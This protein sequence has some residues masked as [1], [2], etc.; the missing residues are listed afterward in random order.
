[1]IVDMT[2]AHAPNDNRLRILVLDD[3]VFD[4]KKVA[5]ENENTI[6]GAQIYS[7]WFS[8]KVV[9]ELAEMSELT[10]RSPFD[11]YIL[12]N[13]LCE[14]GD[15][16]TNPRHKSDGTHVT[17]AG[18][19]AGSMAA[20]RW[21]GHVQALIPWSA[22][23]E[24]GEDFLTLLSSFLPRDGIHF[25]DPDRIRKSS[26]GGLLGVLD[27]H[28]AVT[29]RKALLDAVGAGNA[30]FFPGVVGEFRRLLEVGEEW[31]DSDLAIQVA[32]AAGPRTFTLGALFFEKK[33][34]VGSRSCVPARAVG[35]LLRASRQEGPIFERAREI[36]TVFWKLRM[37]WASFE[38]YGDIRG[39]RKPRYHLT[40]PWLGAREWR[41]GEGVTRERDG[42]RAI[43]L[44]ILFLL[45]LEHRTRSDA[46]ELVPTLDLRSRQVLA[47]LQRMYIDMD[48][49]KPSRSGWDIGRLLRS[50]WDIGV[51]AADALV[52]AS[53]VAHDPQGRIIEPAAFA[54]LMLPAT[55]LVI[56]Y[57]VDP[58]PEPVVDKS[59]NFQY[60]H[61]IGKDT[62]VRKQ[63]DRLLKGDRIDEPAKTLDPFALLSCDGATTQQM[64]LAD[65][66]T[67][68]RRFAAGLMPESKFPTWLRVASA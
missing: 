6:E 48:E 3:R 15:K 5:V 59:G 38:I 46:V 1:M 33:Q 9:S 34:R 50:E 36:A 13:F 63:F 51:E 62:K 60:T 42:V 64:L 45:L 12:D 30:S 44:A 52:R 56:L 26:V 16:C 17:G 20:N 4:D 14:A 35:E 49:D 29:Y 61:T 27:K 22:Y 28:A 65:E 10:E 24:Q 66:W 55:E 31:V 18:L 47:N 39:G 37:S 19:I 67:D 32:T 57:L 7:K 21:R 68:V 23:P 53:R 40:V 25:A 58:L 54:D 8:I 11:V 2:S 41:R 43:R